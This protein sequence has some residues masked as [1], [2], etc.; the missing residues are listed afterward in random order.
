MH[1]LFTPPLLCSTCQ[2]KEKSSYWKSQSQ[3]D[4]MQKLLQELNVLPRFLL[5]FFTWSTWHWFY[6]FCHLLCLRMHCSKV[7]WNYF[8]AQRK[9]SLPHHQAIR[10]HHGIG[11]AMVVPQFTFK[12][13]TSQTLWYTRHQK[14]L[15]ICL[16]FIF[17]DNGQTINSE[18]SPICE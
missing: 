15:C 7:S 9:G 17:C 4:T 6:W 12:P 14:P 13:W 3:L 8:S 2:A 11:D 18:F 16:C 1:I 10:K 5:V